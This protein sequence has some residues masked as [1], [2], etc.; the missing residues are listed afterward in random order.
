MTDAIAAYALPSQLRFLFANL[1]VDMPSPGMELWTRFQRDLCADY[2]Q[3]GK[4]RIRILTYGRHPWKFAINPWRREPEN[5]KLRKNFRESYDAAV[6]E[7]TRDY[8]TACQS[9]T[10]GYIHRS[11]RHNQSNQL[12]AECDT[13]EAAGGGTDRQMGH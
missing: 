12:L 3:C 13:L 7:M 9:P 4:S 6:L 10:K 1:F 2:L 11:A 5:E 8:K